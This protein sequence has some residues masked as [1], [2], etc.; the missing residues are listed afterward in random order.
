MDLGGFSAFA[1]Q[2]P[3]RAQLDSKAPDIFT[4]LK[5]LDDGIRASYQMM[6]ICC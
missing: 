1:G 5:E 4:Y 2:S 6:L 3:S